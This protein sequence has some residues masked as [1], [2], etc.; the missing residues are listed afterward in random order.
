[1]KSFIAAAL[2]SSVLAQAPPTS[3]CDSPPAKG[4]GGLSGGIFGINLGGG[5]PKGG[6]PKNG[7]AKGGSPKS[8]GAD[9]A[10]APKAWDFLCKRVNG[11]TF[12]TGPEYPAVGIKRVNREG[13]GP[14]KSA[15]F[16]R[17]D[18]TLPGHTIYAP[19]VPPLANVKLP[20]IAFGEGGCTGVGTMFPDFLAELASHGYLILANGNPGKVPEVQYTGDS[21]L[22]N[23]IAASGGART[24]PEQLTESIDW[25]LS[26][27]AAKYGNIDTA[28]IAAMGQSCG[29]LEAYSGS[30][31]DDRVKLTILLNSGV[32]DN[33]RKCLLKELKAPVAMFLGGPCDTANL[34]GITDYDLLTVPKFKVHLDAGHSGTY[35]DVNGGK[36]GKAVVA[37]L[38]WQFRGDEKAKLQFAD[39]KSANSFVKQGWY[40]ITSTWFPHYEAKSPYF[41]NTLA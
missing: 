40:N 18:P 4:H 23:A 19:L 37:F 26:G 9:M 32:I 11:S 28:H 2:V 39:P 38:E 30:Y 25:V 7:L 41:N 33:S 16:G 34:N 36:F 13:T 12:P 24:K 14:Y 21:G 29:G 8:V 3:L 1:M 5:L 10:I 15:V 31:H 22:A 27:K 20:V 6:F 35:G 17:T